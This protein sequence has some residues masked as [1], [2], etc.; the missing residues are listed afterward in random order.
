MGS[1]S[2]R[3][4]GIS[5]ASRARGGL[6][7]PRP[8][9]RTHADR[10]YDGPRPPPEQHLLLQLLIAEHREDALDECHWGL[11]QRLR[12]EVAQLLLAEVLLEGAARGETPVAVGTEP[13]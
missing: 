10:P 1:R 8:F 12:D 9:S 4:V 7:R 13:G 6:R 3:S 2:R 11:V 5:S